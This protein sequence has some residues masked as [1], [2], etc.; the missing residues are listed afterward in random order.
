MALALSTAIVVPMLAWAAISDLLYRRISN[1][2]ILLLLL[3][4]L[5]CISWELL[6]GRVQPGQMMVSVLTAATVLGFG[7]LL[8]T[9]RWMGGGDAKLIAV[10]C[11]WLGKEAFT[12]LMVTSIAGGVLAMAVPLV[13]I[14]ERVLGDGV[15]QVNARLPRLALPPPTPQAL[16]GPT[17]GMPY[18][19]AIAF[20]ASVVLWGGL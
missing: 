16:S 9:L 15:M 1:R 8:F 14:V 5:P 10:L 2:L 3:L 6:Q 19:L 12:F 18:G 11:L 17:S 4:W 13:R 7:F 20:G